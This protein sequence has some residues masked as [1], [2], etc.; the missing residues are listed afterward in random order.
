MIMNAL[1]HRAGRLRDP[2][3][4][5]RD[6]FGFPKKSGNV[7]MVSSAACR[8]VPNHAT[9]VIRVVIKFVKNVT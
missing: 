2:T 1:T 8:I 6:V 5:R 9:L 4:R 3:E 7:A